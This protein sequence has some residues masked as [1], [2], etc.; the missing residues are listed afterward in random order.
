MIGSS[1]RREF[2]E[3]LAQRLGAIVLDVPRL[4]DRREDVLPLAYHFLRTAQR[5]HSIEGDAAELLQ[6]YSWPGNVRELKQV[7]EWASIWSATSITRDAL[8]SALA[9][10]FGNVPNAYPE[11]SLERQV[12]IDAL[13]KHEWETQAVAQELKMHRTTVYRLMR[14]YDLSTRYRHRAPEVQQ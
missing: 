2:R 6:A 5:N 10:R 11:R 14:R 12:L 7:V 9:T 4:A 3:D 1:S 8:T 13:E